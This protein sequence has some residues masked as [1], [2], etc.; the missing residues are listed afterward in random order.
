ME[1]L[2]AGGIEHDL[3][4]AGLA[5]WIRDPAD[6][7]PVPASLLH[8]PRPGPARGGTRPAPPGS[9]NGNRHRRQS[10]ARAH[11]ARTAG[12]EAL[13]R[14]TTERADGR[15]RGGHGL[16]GRRRPGRPAPT[17]RRPPASPPSPDT[18]ME[19]DDDP[20]SSRPC[21]DSRLGSGGVRARGI[22]RGTRDLRVRA[23]ARRGH[24]AP[25]RPDH[26]ALT[27]DGGPYH[28]SWPAHRSRPRTWPRPGTRSPS[29]AGT[30]AHCCSAVPAPPTTTSHDPR[31]RGRHHRQASRRSVEYTVLADLPGSGTI[32][33]HDSDRT[34]ATGSW[35]TTPAALPRI[36]G[37]CQ[38]RG[39]QVG[40]LREHGVPGAGAGH[41]V[42]SLSSQQV[43][44][45]GGGVE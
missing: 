6:L 7:G 37:T 10:P 11:A 30:T 18:W 13:L 15:H 36:L 19:T 38:E 45:V 12:G 39:R 2:R 24:A 32:L 31:R 44:P 4:N 9:R 23:A 43:R 33:L 5:A 26:I 17:T 22:A 14:P 34:S 35:R 1:Q 16:S 42:V 40:P 27:F 29:T 8:G 41:S 20:G 21:H 25:G 3:E 28:L